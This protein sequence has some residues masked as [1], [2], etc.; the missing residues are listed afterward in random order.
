M[1]PE[2]CREPNERWLSWVAKGLALIRPLAFLAYA[3]LWTGPLEAGGH[4]ASY[5]ARASTAP[6]SLDPSSQVWT[7]PSARPSA[8]APSSRAPASRSR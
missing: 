3:L 6:A 4:A 1:E 2:H 8:P 7:S 5:L